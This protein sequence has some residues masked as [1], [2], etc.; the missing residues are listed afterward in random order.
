MTSSRGEAEAVAFSPLNVI[1][2]HFRTKPGDGKMS[3]LLDNL[4][5]RVRSVEVEYDVRRVA[6]A[7]EDVKGWIM[8]LPDDSLDD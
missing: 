6:S 8:I 4:R 5:G 2:T 1:V 7:V 3:R